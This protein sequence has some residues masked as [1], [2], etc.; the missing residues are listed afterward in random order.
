[1]INPDEVP[2]AVR[3]TF[4]ASLAEVCH[5]VLQETVSIFLLIRKQLQR[6]DQFFAQALRYR[7]RVEDLRLLNTFPFLHDQ[8]P[9]TPTKRSLPAGNYCSLLVLQRAQ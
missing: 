9:V 2:Q 1:M 7:M 6:I 3:E 8:K 5:N 4:P